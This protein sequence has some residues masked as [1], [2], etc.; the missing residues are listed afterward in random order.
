MRK[1]VKYDSQLSILT[2]I[3]INNRD[4]D[5]EKGKKGVVLYISENRFKIKPYPHSPSSALPQT[6]T[7]RAR[8]RPPEI[9]NTSSYT[10]NPLLLQEEEE[11]KAP[12]KARIFEKESTRRSGGEVGRKRKEVSKKELFRK[13]SSM[14]RKNPRWIR[15]GVI[16]H[17]LLFMV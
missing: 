5:H 7:P 17:F 15:Q 12:D 16:R 2:S 11:G 13:D 4:H 3:R 10:L 14:D 6:P 9:S 1:I 8:S